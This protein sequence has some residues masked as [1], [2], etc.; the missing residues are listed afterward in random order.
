M[1]YLA[2]GLYMIILDLSILYCSF[3]MF[4]LLSF[5]ENC[6]YMCSLSHCFFL[7]SL[8]L[9]LSFALST[10]YV[11]LLISSFIYRCLI[12]DFE[13]RPSVTHLLEHPFIKQAHGKDT[14]LRQR[15]SVLIREQQDMGSRTKTRYILPTTQTVG[16]K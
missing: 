1:P 15:L 7:C 12:K 8:S 5:M 13:T 14:S 10:S 11:I 9:C 16:V 2:E 3:F 6:C 4:I